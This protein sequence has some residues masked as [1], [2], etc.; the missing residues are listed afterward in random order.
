MLPLIDTVFVWVAVGTTLI[1]I[2]DLNSSA[3]YLSW[4][5]WI[6]VFTWHN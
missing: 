1:D 6:A 5:R 3:V 2:P 4:Q